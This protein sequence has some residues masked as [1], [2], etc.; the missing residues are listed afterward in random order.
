MKLKVYAAHKRKQTLAC[1]CMQN[2]HKRSPLQSSSHLKTQMCSSSPFR[3]PMSLLVSCTLKGEPK[4]ARNLLMCICSK[5]VTLE[6]L[7]QEKGRSALSS[8]RRRT[9]ST[10]MHL[11]GWE[12]NGQCQETSP[13]CSK[14]L[15]VN[16]MLP[17]AQALP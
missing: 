2:M 13:A 16:C 11:P 14:S 4:P 10:K 12:K 1:Y 5:A 6:A 7:L 3:L 8:L 17:D 9:G 15:P